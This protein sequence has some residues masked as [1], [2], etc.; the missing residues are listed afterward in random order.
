MIL[1]MF[2]VKHFWSNSKTL[3][4]ENPPQ[5]QP[6]HAPE[7]ARLQASPFHRRYL[8]AFEAPI[9]AGTTAAAEQRDKIKQ[10]LEVA[11]VCTSRLFIQQ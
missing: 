5:G 10:R 7:W 6:R 9:R 8:A 11:I 1:E 3:A 4:L 2:H